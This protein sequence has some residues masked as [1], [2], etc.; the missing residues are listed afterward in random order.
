MQTDAKVDSLLKCIVLDSGQVELEVVFIHV[1]EPARIILHAAEV[2]E[3]LRSKAG[4]SP[5]RHENNDGLFRAVVLN[6]QERRPVHGLHQGAETPYFG[7]AV[8]K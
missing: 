6:G 5:R 3:I 2:D 1:Q 8:D 4:L 7:E